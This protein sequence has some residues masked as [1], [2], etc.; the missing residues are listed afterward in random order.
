MYD[1]IKSRYRTTPGTIWSAA[2][3]YYQTLCNSPWI[4]SVLILASFRVTGWQPQYRAHHR[5]R[6][7]R[8]HLSCVSFL[9][10]RNFSHKPLSD[11]LLPHVIQKCLFTTNHQRGK[12]DHHLEWM[13]VGDPTMAS[14]EREPF[15]QKKYHTTLWYRAVR[16]RAPWTEVRD[17]EEARTHPYLPQSLS[18][19]SLELFM[20]VW[21]PL[22]LISKAASHTHTI[23]LCFWN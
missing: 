4:S 20:P 18:Q 14:I 7:K 5:P 23:A 19:R 22:N 16:S 8:I 9:G 15:F 1:L 11:F 21:K 3:Q 10:T 12:W 17:G 13:Y 6:K 2:H